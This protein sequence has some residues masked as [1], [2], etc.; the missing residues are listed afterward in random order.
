M[1]TI[2]DKLGQK[3]EVPIPVAWNALTECV[4]LKLLDCLDK[5]VQGRNKH[6]QLL[7][8]GLLGLKAAGEER[9]WAQVQGLF[10]LMGGAC[11]REGTVSCGFAGRWA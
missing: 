9:I 2:I 8:G 4:S 10:G 3:A 6:V 1:S 5:L 7:Q 11:R